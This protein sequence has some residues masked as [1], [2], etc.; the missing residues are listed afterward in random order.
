MRSGSGISRRE[1]LG[2]AGLLAAGLG[3]PNLISNAAAARQT[4]AAAD[5]VLR[6]FSYA[7]VQFPAGLAQS[8]LEETHAVL[9]GLS[10]DNLL[11]P[12][13]LREGLPAPGKDLGG[14]YDA[15]AF[16]PG[17]TFGQWMSAL[18]RYYAITGDAATREKVDNLV[19]GYAATIDPAGK[20]YVEN[21]FP[22]YGYDKL[23]C[24]L[25]DAHQFAHNLTAPDALLRATQAAVNHLPG[26]AVPRQETPV[27]DREDFTRHCWDE[28]YTLPENLFLAWQRGGDTRYLEMAKQYLFDKEYFDPL[29]RG[30]NILPGLHAYSHAN[31]LS[32]AAM[33]YLVL[34]DDKYLRAATNGFD[35]VS[36]QSFATGGWGP[37]EHFVAPGSGGLG[38]SLAKTHLSFETPC[39]AYAHFKIT[40]YLLR[41]TQDPRYGDSM[42]RVLYN[43][44]LGAKPLQ[45][46][47]RAF[48]YSDYNFQG[49][50]IYHR[51]KWPCCSG[52]LPQIAADYR[53]SAYLWD[54]MGVYV[55]LYLPSTL[56]WTN[57]GARLELTQ[58]GA[59]PLSPE[60]NVQIRASRPTNFALRLRIPE[61]AGDRGIL[62]VNGKSVSIRVSG[63]TFATLRR[64]W[65]DGD[66]VELELPLP[67]RLEAVDKLHPDTVAVVR[68]PLVLFAL[69]DKAPQ[70]TRPQLLAVRQTMPGSEEFLVDT[71]TSSLRLR[72][73]TAIQDE[74]YSAYLKVTWPATAAYPRNAF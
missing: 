20:F 40:R 44:V 9:M 47:G 2:F 10:D 14:W 15:F 68:G 19:K 63:A 73:F 54:A 46:D 62:R 59:Y 43:S 25:I 11:R 21:R 74:P 42:E 48:Y 1:F 29:A 12:F 65:K 41:I 72:P 39:G 71:G 31:A 30:E 38:E 35:M 55:N 58:S 53:I 67:I 49:R 7:D 6:E 22:A 28:S 32:S 69:T 36:Q 60:I 52:T 4:V 17:C 51:D 13:R 45:P 61:W 5:S 3:C 33:A 34:Q 56:R 26:K 66:R 64:T 70:V 23:V 57:G 37:E 24:G 50:K 27:L 16:A 8:Q 18:A